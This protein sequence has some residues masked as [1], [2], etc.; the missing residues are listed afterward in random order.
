MKKGIILWVSSILF[1]KLAISCSCHRDREMKVSEFW[2][3]AQEREPQIKT[4]FFAGKKI[5]KDNKRINCLNY[6]QEGCRQG[7]GKRLKLRMVELLTL[8]YQTREQACLAAQEIGEWYAFNWL[9]DGVSDE[10]VLE[11]FVVKAF[12]AIKPPPSFLCY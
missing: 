5:L 3:R 7:S 9:F 11:D 4:V 1:F 2:E 6:R 8:Q 10:P 12:G